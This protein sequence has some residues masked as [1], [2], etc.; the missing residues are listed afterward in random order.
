KNKMPFTFSADNIDYK[1]FIDDVEVMKSRYERSIS[2]P[3]DDSA[4]VSFP[5]TVFYKDL[6]SV[7]KKNERQKNDSVIYRIESSFDTKLI[8]KKRFD[9]KIERRLPLIYIPEV[10][11]GKMEVDSLKLSG[12]SI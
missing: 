8:V 7:L 11:I 4:W 10:K 12:A 5:V 2:L 9:V 6:V 3:G 1:V